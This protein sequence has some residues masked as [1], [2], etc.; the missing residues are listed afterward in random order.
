M[1]DPARL[2]ER[3]LNLN[4]FRAAVGNQKR[5]FTRANTFTF[6]QAQHAST[7][8]RA[9]GAAGVV[10]GMGME[11]ESSR[12][13]QQP[14][15][16]S[17]AARMTGLAVGGA[18]KPLIS[19]NTFQA[20]GGDDGF[21][22]GFSFP[23]IKKKTSLSTATTK[24]ATDDHDHDDE[25]EENDRYSA[26]DSS[27]GSSTNDAAGSSPCGPGR[28]GAAAGGDSPC[29]PTSKTGGGGG[30]RNPFRMAKGQGMMLGSAASGTGGRRVLE[31]A[32]TSGVLM[33]TR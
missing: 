23:A 21:D 33:F 5:Q 28:G 27:F 12:Q 8:L 22:R 10:D 14:R 32:Q 4:A 25:D 2:A 24:S 20:D 13:Q 1:D 26:A 11:M 30:L 17:M 15:P 16:S 3:S 7:I 6:G 9:A 31:R 18:R 19:R 29:P